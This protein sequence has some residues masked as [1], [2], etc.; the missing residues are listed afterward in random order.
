MLVRRRRR[1]V[2]HA[3]QVQRQFIVVVL[4]QP[5]AQRAA[6]SFRG[7]EVVVAEQVVT[8]GQLQQPLLDALHA[9]PVDAAVLAAVSVDLGDV[10]HRGRH[11][12]GSLGC[13]VLLAHIP[14]L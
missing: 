4:G 8:L 14:Q 2:V 6:R 10:V 5:V 11:R 13:P 9:G 12:R 1:A 7:R 3:L